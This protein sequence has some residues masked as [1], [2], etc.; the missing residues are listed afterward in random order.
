MFLSSSLVIATMMFSG[1]IAQPVNYADGAT[2][3]NDHRYAEAR[4]L[5]LDAAE[6]G[7]VKSMLM[8]G[9]MY[10]NG[11]GDPRDAGL[12]FYWYSQAAVAGN[13]RAMFNLYQMLEEGDGTYVDQ[14]EATAWLEKSAE[15]GFPEAQF[16][17]AQVL[18]AGK[19]LP[20]DDESAL[21]WLEIVSQ[22]DVGGVGQAIQL[23]DQLRLKLDNAV[24]LRAKQRAK[25]WKATHTTSN[26]TLI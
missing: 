5:F 2:A 13:A 17:W 9:L 7:D 8:L 23:R 18:H 1:L 20:Q 11:M 19:R 22:I 26:T 12:A 16:R 3:Y 14:K 10:D 25:R 15:K 21:M 4:T 6:A 24:V